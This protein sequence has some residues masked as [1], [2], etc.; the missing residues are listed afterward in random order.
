MAAMTWL[1]MFGNGRIAGTDDKKGNRVLRGGSWVSAAGHLRSSDRGGGSPTDWS[2]GV[3]FRCA[4]TP[5]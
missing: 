1:V 3:G 4:R 5:G 2:D